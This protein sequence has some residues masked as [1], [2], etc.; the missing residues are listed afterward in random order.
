MCEVG[1]V[2]LCWCVLSHFSC[3]RLFATLWTI[4]RQALLPMGILQARILEW[5]A[6]HSSRGSSRPRNRTLISYVSCIAGRFFTTSYTFCSIVN[7]LNAPKWAY[8]MSNFLWTLL[9]ITERKTNE[10]AT[11]N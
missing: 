8:E 10:G 5:D 6:M 1:Y 3:V 4:V 9:I 11:N 2:P 7:L